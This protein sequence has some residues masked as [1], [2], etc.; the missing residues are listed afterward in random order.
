M[1][2]GNLKM[3][4]MSVEKDGDEKNVLKRVFDVLVRIFLFTHQFF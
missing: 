1:R 4:T 2:D 3:K